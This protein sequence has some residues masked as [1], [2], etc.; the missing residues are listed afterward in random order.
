MAATSPESYDLPLRNLHDVEALERMPLDERI[1]SWNLNDWIDRGLTR[2]PGKIALTYVAD[3]NPAG[4]AV[5][6]AYGELQQRRT[7]IANLLHSVGVQPGDVVLLLLPTLPQLY[8]ALVGALA[9]ATPCCVNWMLKPAQL[10]ELVRSTRARAI[11]CLGPTPGYE[12][13]ENVQQIRQEIGGVRVLTVPGPGGEAQP[14]TDLDT[15]A[16]ALPAD[17]LMFER[18]KRTNDIA[19]LVHS[20]GTT[21]APKLVQLTHRGFAYKCWANAVVMAHSADDVVLADYPMFHIAGLF[22]RGLF[23]LA[24]GMAIVIPSPLGARDKRFIDNYWRFIETFRITYFSGVPTTLATLAKHPPKG[25]DLGSLRP[26]MV[27]GSTAMPAEI[28]RAIERMIGVRV[29]LSYGATEFTQNITQAPRDGDPRYGSAGLRLPYTAVKTVKLDDAGEIARDCAVGEIGMVVVKGPSVTPGYLD[30][31]YNAG[32]FTADGWIKNG[33]LGRIDADGYLWLTGRAKD[34][35]IRGG[36]NIDPSVIE[37]AL[38]KHPAV[39]LA[40]AIGKPDAYAGELPVAYVQLVNGAT[41]TAEELSGFALATI[42]ERA[43]APKEIVILERMPLT[44]VGKPAK[45]QL[46]RD[47]AQRVFQN[48]LAEAVGEAARIEVE[49]MPDEATGTTAVITMSAAH[50]SGRADAEA[51]V[52]T[53]MAGYATAHRVEWSE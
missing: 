46:R 5:R 28:G 4:Q 13:W 9:C 32:L 8:S 6:L 44:D 31:R 2:D 50:A 1:F 53:L 49:V 45:P 40:A 20:G 24:H 52:R 37:E 35:I 16:S 30:P 18:T 39:L 34:V 14:D 42:P 22:A 10:A 19:A 15:L 33:D 25:E 21:G 48:V 12:I 47:A 41:A 51:R 38:Q 3:G 27:T 23:A 36:H 7:Q 26:Y 29:L 43:A 11:V 17:R